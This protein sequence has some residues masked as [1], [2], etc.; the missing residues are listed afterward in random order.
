MER[1]L[2]LA[3]LASELAW[4]ADEAPAARDRIA[5]ALYSLASALVDLVV[6]EA[7]EPRLIREAGALAEKVKALLREKKYAEAAVALLDLVMKW[8]GG[9]RVR[10]RAH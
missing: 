10:A 3:R 1:A 4:L 7:R 9:Q 5:R 6:D 8:S 2:L